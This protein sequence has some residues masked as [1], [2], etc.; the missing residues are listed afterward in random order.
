MSTMK[1]EIVSLLRKEAMHPVLLKDLSKTQRKKV[2]R[3]CMFLKEKFMFLKVSRERSELEDTTSPTVKL[4]SVMIMLAVAANLG[5]TG[6]THD[7]GTA[8]MTG[9]EVYIKLDKVMSGLLT[10]IKPEYSVFV[11]DRDEIAMKL[12][13]ALYG[14]VQ[15]ARLWYER[16]KKALLKWDYEVHELDPCVFTK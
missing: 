15:S 4:V 3:S 10:Q 12:D 7:V 5:Y 8:E 1:Q 6:S 14:C 2:L 13:K 16:L 11:D 9:E